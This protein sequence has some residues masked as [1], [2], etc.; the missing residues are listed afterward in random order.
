MLRRLRRLCQRLLTQG[1]PGEVSSQS[2]RSVAMMGTILLHARIAGILFL[3]V[4]AILP[5]ARGQSARF[6]TEEFSIALSPTATSSVSFGAREIQRYIYLASGQL[7]PIA[8]LEVANGPNT[9]LVLARGRLTLPPE[10][11]GLERDEYCLRSAKD[12]SGH[13]VLRLSGGSPAGLLYAVYRLAEHLGVRFYLTEE[14]APESRI[15]FAIPDLNERRKP[16]FAVRGILPFHDFAEGPDWWNADDYLAII[17]Q[18]PKLGM[19][20]IGLHTYP[21][22]DTGPEPTVWIG[23]R[24]NFDAQGRVTAAYPASY[25]TTERS[26]HGWWNYAPTH[27][28]AFVAG[29]AQLFDQDDFGT[30][31]MG[32]HE[33]SR[34]TAADSIQVFNSTGSLL[35][36][37]FQEAHRL[38]VAT[39]IGTETPLTLPKQV[40]AQ[41][42]AQKRDLQRPGWA[43]PYYEAIFERIDRTLP[44]DYFWLWTPEE[45]TWE[46]NKPEAFAA[47]QED[48]EAATSALKAV[49][50]RI[51]L[52]TCGWV[53]GPQSNR[54]ALDE[55]LPSGAPMSAI[56]R[57]VGN[58]AID[59]QFANIN[60]RPRWAIPWLEND[61][62]L[63][64]LQ[65]WT[66]RMRYD[67]ADAARLG[68]TG[69]IGIHWHTQ[70]LAPAVAALAQAEWDQSYLPADFPQER[71]GPQSASGADGGHPMPPVPL[72]GSEPNASNRVGMRGY[73]LLVPNGTYAVRLGFSEVE[74]RPPG[75]RRFSVTVQGNSIAEH[76]V[77]PPL[78]LPLFVTAKDV[79]VEDSSLRIGF[80]PEA[81][82]PA[83]ASIEVSGTTYVN[84]ATFSRR[85]NCGGLQ[86]R[87]FEADTLPSTARP[88][89]DRTAGTLDFYLEFA[90]ANFGATVA[91]AA[92]AI[93]A[94]VDGTHLPCPCNWGDGPGDIT[95]N[96]KPWDEVSKTY[97]FV[98][99][100]ERLRPSV[101]GAGNLDRFGYWAAQFEALR[102]LGEIG[103]LAGE[104]DRVCDS[105]PSSGRASDAAAVQRAVGLRLDLARLWE[106]LIQLEIGGVRSTGELG[107]IANL[108]TRSRLHKHIL[109]KDDARLVAALGRPLPEEIAVRKDYEGPPRILM[110]T[111]RRSASAGEAVVVRPILVAERPP[112]G[113][114]LHWRAIGE[115]DYH[116]SP[117][118]LEA[119]SVYR[120]V[121]PDLGT[122]R[123]AIEYY[124]EADLDGQTVRWP[125]EAPAVGQTVVLN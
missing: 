44:L 123:P 31:S 87:D 50:S 7:V 9:L 77:P 52:A 23:L 80:Q 40:A 26:G 94:A 4:V 76:L 115:S 91:Q 54:S 102:H 49:H 106:E 86:V 6:G 78:P 56:N 93:F 92:G 121:L 57:S 125:A 118:A 21:E 111:V 110:T 16:L 47:I 98:T 33:Y 24:G 38:G 84:A 42:A 85:I 12:A 120:A 27:T 32:G 73:E 8:T 39:C 103:C 61:P 45:W 117:L 63:S 99:Q 119:R 11:S 68:C 113:A 53:L 28:A 37:A 5:C 34:Q 107:T 124:L 30:E 51:Q 17:G 108:E 90:R 105:F 64:A 10:P 97:D 19:N 122:N 89:T 114:T 70:S 88:P 83:I 95:R 74:G 48:I 71:L 58:D 20:F 81:G 60:D 75:E 82:E 25:H 1:F 35:R 18:L 43:E 62:G 65:L 104:L 112:A 109:D 13:A 100:F 46:G 22:G 66:G 3:V 69:L 96:S 29:A 67:A 55:L 36:T 79:R 2:D 59:R 15:P 72:P 41:A 116:T 14:V 101:V